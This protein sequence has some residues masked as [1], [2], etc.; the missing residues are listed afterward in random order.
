[1]ENDRSRW[2]ELSF[3]DRYAVEDQETAR[4]A[5]HLPAAGAG[6]GRW[7]CPSLADG[8]HRRQAR[9][10]TGVIRKDNDDTATTGRRVY[11]QAVTGRAKG[12]G[13]R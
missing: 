10:M 4:A 5:G 8:L 6:Y 1:M 11:L 7:E 3:P 12:N 2:R 13:T 9:R